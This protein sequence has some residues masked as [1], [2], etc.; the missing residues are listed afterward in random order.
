MSIITSI[1]QAIFQ[2]IC[3]ILPISET[4][5][6]SI[7]HSFSALLDGVYSNLTG[8][9][10]IGIAIGIFLSMYKY[11]LVLGKEFLKTLTDVFKKRLNTKEV[12]QPRKVLY[13]S[14]VAYAP[15][16]L[17]LI[18]CGKGKL[19][20][21]ILKSTQYNKSLLD[22]G[23]FLLL[24]GAMILVA[25]IIINKDKDTKNI[26]L[27]SALVVGFLSLLFVPVSGLSLVAGAFVVLTLFCVSK[28]I[29][30]KFGLVMSV[31]ILLILGFVQTFSSHIRF[32]VAPIIIGLIVSIITSFLMVR[33]FNFIVNKK[34]IKYFGIY[35]ITLGG[36]IAIVG[37]FQL[38]FR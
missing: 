31:P 34:Y 7:F 26:S 28:K 25:S 12:S 22:D 6:S 24:L 29:S 17:W 3:W 20:Y 9:V 5:H 38:I 37:I 21:S 16:L 18:P 19:L 1:F 27:L 35:D 2:A 10:H 23:I 11:F 8:I 13:L 30:A 33:I 32:G 15:L 36:I 14:L 4:A